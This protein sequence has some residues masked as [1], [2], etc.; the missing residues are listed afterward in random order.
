MAAPASASEFELSPVK[1]SRLTK[2]GIILGLSLPQV[3]AVS[4]AVAVFV[5]SLYAG[6]PAA[7]YTA[8]IWG[9]ALGLAA[10]PVGG[11]KLVEWVPIELVKL[12]V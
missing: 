6:G 2:R 10:I 1:F 7:L 4:V 5:A 9:T 8:P 11:R 12:C 3:I